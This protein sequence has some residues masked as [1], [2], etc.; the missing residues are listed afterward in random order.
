MKCTYIKACID[1]KRF[2]GSNKYDFK[3]G[4][5]NQLLTSICKDWVLDD[6]YVEANFELGFSR[7]LNDLQKTWCL[8]SIDVG[9]F[10]VKDDIDQKRIEQFQPLANTI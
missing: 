7:L 9:I 8:P 4:N 5:P 10:F 1:H 2:D 3:T 6:G